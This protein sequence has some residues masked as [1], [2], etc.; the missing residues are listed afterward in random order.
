MIVSR[1]GSWLDPP[2]NVRSAKRG[3]NEPDFA[4]YKLGIRCAR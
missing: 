1:G 3:R 4:I 2:E